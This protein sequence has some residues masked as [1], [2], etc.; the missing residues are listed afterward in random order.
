MGVVLLLLPSPACCDVPSILFCRRG[1]WNYSS[2]TAGVARLN[3][4]YGFTGKCSLLQKPD[5]QISTGQ[6][7]LH[8]DERK[9]VQ[10]N[11]LVSRHSIVHHRLIVHTFVEWSN[12]GIFNP[13]NVLFLWCFSRTCGAC[14]RA[15]EFAL[16]PKFIYIFIVITFK[17]IW[18]ALCVCVCVCWW[19]DA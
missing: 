17:L 19:V 5:R 8:C 9:G 2:L 7:C 11:K 15:C 13:F 4:N 6:A 18:S 14:S 16:K 10:R 1:I 12:I 3:T